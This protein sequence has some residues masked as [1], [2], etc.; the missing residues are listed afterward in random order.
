MRSIL[1]LTLLFLLVMPLAMSDSVD[2]L[3]KHESQP[4]IGI[5][6]VSEPKTFYETR[7]VSLKEYENLKLSHGDRVR[8]NPQ[9]TTFLD[10]STEVIRANKTWNLQVNNTNLT[11]IGETVCIVD[12]GVNYRHSAFGS[13]EPE[14]NTTSF[15]YSLTQEETPTFNTSNENYDE[16]LFWNG[17]VNV[18]HKPSYFF[19]SVNL[20]G[21]DQLCLLYDSVT[22][23]CIDS[24]QSSYA[25]TVFPE[26]GNV[27]IVLLKET[28]AS[29]SS[30]NLSGYTNYISDW[31]S[32]E[33]V[34]GG[35]NFNQR[36]NDP[37]DSGTHGTHVASTVMGNDETIRGVAPGS[38]LF[39]SRALDAQSGSFLDVGLA[40]GECIR[41]ADKH[42][43]S[44]IVMSLG[45]KDL[46]FTSY[47]DSEPDYELVKNKINEATQK[48][49][50]VAVAT[51][52]DNL[53]GVASPA[54]I[55]NST[56]VASTSKQ[57]VFSS[58]N[59]RGGVF[60]DVLLAPGEN[61]L[62]AVDNNNYNTKSGTSMATPHVAG[63]AII[64]RQISRLQNKNELT[65][66][67]IIH[68]LNETGVFV[69][70]S[71]SDRNY[72]RIN[73]FDALNGSL[74]V[75]LTLS[76]TT[77]RLGNNLQ[78]NYFANSSTG[79]ITD[80]NLTVLKDSEVVYFSSNTSQTFID[81]NSSTLNETGL[82][83][84]NLT[85]KSDSNITTNDYKTFF[86][87]KDPE[88]NVTFLEDVSELIFHVNNSVR[89]NFTTPD[90]LSLNFSINSSQ[91]AVF[92]ENTQFNISLLEG[93]YDFDFV[94]EGTSNFFRKNESYVVNV[95]DLS[96]VLINSSPT[97]FNLTREVG[98][99][100]NFTQ[101]SSSPENDLN[102]TWSVNTI[103]Q[104]T[105]ASYQFNTTNLSEGT[106]N[107]TL[108]VSNDFGLVKR[109]WNI[110]LFESLK[111][112]IVSFTPA[113]T[114]TS[115]SPGSDLIF[116]LNTSTEIEETT[117]YEW[118]LNNVSVENSSNYTFNEEAI[119]IYNLT[120]IT[121]NSYGNN[122]Q[123][124]TVNVLTLNIINTTP[125]NN[126][127]TLAQFNTENFSVTTDSN[128]S[129]NYN[130]SLNN[131]YVGNDSSYF[132]NTSDYN[133]GEYDLFVNV[134]NNDTYAT[135]SWNVFI[136][137]PL[138][139]SVIDFSPNSSLINAS[140]DKGVLF[141]Q[142]SSDVENRSLTYNWF[143]NDSLN[144]TTQ[145]FTFVS[146]AVGRFNISLVVSNGWAND[147]KS[148]LVD[149]FNN[150]IDFYN[151]VSSI[152]FD[153]DASFSINI[154]EHFNYSGYLDINTSL[155]NNELSSSFEN[156]LLEIS[157]DVGEFE[158]NIFVANS[159]FNATSNNFSVLVNS[160]TPPSSGGGGGSSGGGGFTSPPTTDDEE[161]S[162]EATDENIE[163]DGGEEENNSVEEVI[164]NSG[165]IRFV[166][167]LV[168]N[169][170]SVESNREENTLQR[171]IVNVRSSLSNFSLEIEEQNNYVEVDRP[172]YKFIILSYNE[173]F[174]DEF[175]H[176]TLDF[177]VNRSWLSSQNIS[178]DEVSL[179][180]LENS[181]WT[182]QNTTYLNSS[183]S[184]AYFT[185]SFTGLSVFS[186]MSVFE[187]EQVAL[188]KE[189]PSRNWWT[190]ILGFLALTI[191]TALFLA[192]KLNRVDTETFDKIK[193]VRQTKQN[194]MKKQKK[195]EKE[196]TEELYSELLQF[197]TSKRRKS[198]ERLLR[199]TT[200]TDDLNELRRLY[201]LIMNDYEK[202]KEK[203]K[204]LYQDRV[205][206]VY[207]EIMRLQK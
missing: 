35:F 152:E 51:G 41:N 42:N 10:D 31:S 38:K 86:V 45:T 122:S 63:A 180:R 105:N 69:Y 189:T 23:E 15:N 88:F 149:V 205:L 77:V 24:N 52:N 162:E 192:V 102:I 118:L 1:L 18:S 103:T 90:L 40:V 135:H 78:I 108:N 50:T 115:I 201:L 84:V 95:T 85:A 182:R 65:R 96:P 165:F 106:Y 67:D 173:S 12:S 110:S 60:D 49:I 176:A 64:L 98:E 6:S 91:T 142:T 183:A 144:S 28:N 126:N 136:T 43:I 134:S 202:L 37:D 191:V 151:N 131:T 36:T 81:V 169:S 57:D 137:E 34:V 203:D 121:Y 73:V 166:R 44:S 138:P 75:N 114:N 56:R 164:E 194:M 82:Y 132:L 112:Q 181:T 124:W 117:R 153:E 154:S 17:S 2:I 94:Q 22:Y 72:T 119:A 161:E 120:A 199:K 111:P 7:S 93:L 172:V 145:N 46:S 61:I 68:K 184:F 9:V 55:T 47:C 133:V 186:V 80:K 54:C 48:N 14:F 87:K 13:C 167:N 179:H 33:R 99:V 97:Q 195:I 185:S 30:F 76:N 206:D 71:V 109:S 159:E 107:I 62:A 104:S 156:G 70:D 26:G 101:N 25:T 5:M 127:I 146:E 168:E 123:T 39:I 83:T 193:P 113:Q 128:E 197:K 79:T 66:E 207:N 160:V 3:V 170:F 8:K 141:N 19:D 147:S 4:Q 11:G 150:S 143:V 58:F 200:K 130:W 32:C 16:I 190:L 155:S 140:L 139:V 89:F 178:V 53:E 204:K 174:S 20:T 92:T 187:E 116:S 59:N 163:E 158:T 157:G 21:T 196:D 27:E 148:V 100:I 175:D 74:I 177:K 198:L 188:P 129:L 125:I 171:L 29:N